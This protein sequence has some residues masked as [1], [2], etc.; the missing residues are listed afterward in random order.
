MFGTIP[1]WGIFEIRVALTCQ[2]HTFRIIGLVIRWR[3]RVCDSRKKL[4]KNIRQRIPMGVS[5]EKRS[6]LMAKNKTE[7]NV[8]AAKQVSPAA[9][10]DSCH[11]EM[12]KTHHFPSHSNQKR[13]LNRIKGQLD[14][15]DK[16][17][18]DNRYCLDIMFQIRAASSALKALEK[19]IMHTH[20]KSCV[21]AAIESTDQFEAQ[22]KI[23]EI[24]DFF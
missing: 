14:G 16:M 3:L 15:I 22:E 13:R 4:M 20:I 24:M 23:D 8:S 1:P 17:I 5:K 11:G 10:L 7:K 6:K 19:E 12:N 2:M 21:K 9:K 18:D